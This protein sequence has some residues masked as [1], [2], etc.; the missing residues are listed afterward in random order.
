M[1][2][3]GMRFTHFLACQPNSGESRAGLLTGC[4]PNRIGFSGAPGPGS[5]YGIHP[6][7]ITMAEMLK[8]KDYK[9]AI[10]GKWHLGDDEQFLPLQNGFDDY[11]G[12]PYSND[13]WPFIHNKMRDLT[14]QTCLHTME[15]K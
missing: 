7:E 4:Y 8:Q 15:M 11:Y 6:D 10:Y 5:D 3:K 12:L 14:F 9:T 2:A 13:I 1:A